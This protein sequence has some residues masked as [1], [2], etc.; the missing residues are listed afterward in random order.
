MHIFLYIHFHLASF[1]S[2]AST[3][4]GQ[5]PVP[6]PP[7]LHSDSSYHLLLCIFFDTEHIW[8]HTVHTSSVCDLRRSNR[9][10]ILLSDRSSAVQTNAAINQLNQL[11]IWWDALSMIEKRVGANK[12]FLV[13][14]C[15]EGR[16][17][18]EGC[19]DYLGGYV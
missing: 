18:C 11:V 3:V 1:D 4:Y 17:M 19:Y 7:D 5:D 2:P 8:V 6:A 15:D 12:E 9:L 13:S 14:I 16:R 10:D